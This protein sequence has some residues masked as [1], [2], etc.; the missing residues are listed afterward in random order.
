V[1]LAWPAAGADRARKLEGLQELLERREW[2]QAAERAERLR[3]DL[4]ADLEEAES[5]LPSIAQTLVLQAIAEANLGRDE[6]AVWHWQTAENYLPGLAETDLAA[7]GRAAEILASEPPAAAPAPVAAANEPGKRRDRYREVKIRTAVQP[8]YPKSLRK[9]GQEGS[10]VVRVVVG[11]DGRPHRPLVKDA[12]I[13]PTMA[14]PALEALQ[15]W[16]F[17]PAERDGQPIEVYYEL[18][19][20]YGQGV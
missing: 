5:A 19:I 8:T 7:Y 13:V 12:G 1:L 2:K 14:F 16:R 6:K 18:R 20:R 10:V 11:L 3:E 4:V 17:A 15:A 9:T